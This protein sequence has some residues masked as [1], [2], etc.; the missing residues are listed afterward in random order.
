MVT[1]VGCGARRG[2]MLI[3][4]AMRANLKLAKNLRKIRLSR[5]ITQETLAAQSGI[6]GN[7]VGRIEQG[8]EN[9][10][11]GLVDDLAEALGIDFRELFA[12]PMPGEKT[13]KPLRGGRRPGSR[14][15]RR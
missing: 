13:P 12:D 2:N 7:Y 9:P 6:S 5:G 11:V 14:R 8:Q 15:P 3:R 10:S 4:P 1:I